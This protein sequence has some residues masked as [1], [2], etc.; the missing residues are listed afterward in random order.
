MI[1]KIEI[2]NFKA[3]RKSIIKIGNLCI[4]S[5]RNGMGK[6]SIIQSLLLLRQSYLSQ[7]TFLGLLL[8]GDLVN[9]GNSQDAFCDYSSENE[10]MFSV[11]SNSQTWDM[12]FKR[13]NDKNFLPLN[14][15]INDSSFSNLNLFSQHFQYIAAEHIASQESHSRNTYYVEQL[16]QISEKLGDAK[17]TVHFLSFNADRDIPLSA[18]G[19]PKAKSLKLK[20][21]V[22]AWLGEISPNVNA[23]V[24]ESSES[25]SLTLHFAYDLSSGITSEYKPENVGFGISYALPLIVSILSSPANSLIIVENP[26]SHLHPGGQSALGRLI[27]KAGQAG[28]Q[29]VVETHSDH[30]INAALI[31]A[32]NFS[33]G[34]NNEM[35]ISKL[36]I[37]FVDRKEGMA[38]TSTI[39][40]KVSERGRISSAPKNFFDQFSE[41]MKQIVGF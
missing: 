25:N 29:L 16:N 28:M 32:L 30:I 5:G 31:S 9:I 13:S 27:C 12:A 37:Y 38:E 23:V 18:L 19:H 33:K 2:R 4:L 39:E 6:S 35:D 14:A 26:E 10:I 22:N 17:Y 24:K 1:D 7:R 20:D 34:E 8:G 3:H 21:Q 41:D 40:I 11:D 36:N 15:P